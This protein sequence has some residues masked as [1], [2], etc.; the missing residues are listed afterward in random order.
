[1]R[2]EECFLIQQKRAHLGNKTELEQKLKPSLRK[3]N[4]LWCVRPPW[5]PEYP[6]QVGVGC[7]KWASSLTQ[8][9]LFGPWVYYSR[10]VTLLRNGWYYGVCLPLLSDSFCALSA[11]CTLVFGDA[12]CAP[13]AAQSFQSVGRCVLDIPD[14][15]PGLCCYFGSPAMTMHLG[16]WSN[17]RAILT[18]SW[19]PCT[20]LTVMSCDEVRLPLARGFGLTRF[21]LQHHLLMLFSGLLSN[22]HCQRDSSDLITDW[23]RGKLHDSLFVI[24]PPRLIF[25]F[26]W[27]QKPYKQIWFYCMLLMARAS[28]AHLAHSPQCKS[29]FVYW[30]WAWLLPKGTYL[31]SALICWVVTNLRVHFVCCTQTLITAVSVRET[32]LNQAAKVKEHLSTS[33]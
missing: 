21:E 29:H 28:M 26:F 7:G 8:N 16:P 19:E 22:F 33:L 17:N 6:A 10:C 27:P 11:S 5:R 30:S 25:V 24:P 13:E 20:L 9:F 12:G 2:K 31:Q 3:L 4:P 32:Y 18:R 15:I 23:S 1:M 14:Q